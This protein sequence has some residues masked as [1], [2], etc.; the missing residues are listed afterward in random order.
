M[1]TP[2]MDKVQAFGKYAL[3]EKLGEG[4]LGPVYRG[5]DQDLGQAVVIRILCDGIKWDPAIEQLYNTHCKAIADL[6]HRNIVAIHDFG[7]EGQ[8][9]YIVME[10]LGSHSIKDIIVQK[11]A[12][13]VETKLSMMIQVAEGM[14]YAHK[15]G[16]LHYD[17]GPSKIHLTS[18]GCIKIRDFGIASVLKNRLPHPAVRFGV[19]IYLSPEQVQ[20]KNGDV[21]SDI[22][23][24]GTIFYELITY[25]HPFHDPN[26]NIALD[27]ILSDKPIPTFERFPEAPP[28]IWTILKTCL[29]KDPRDRYPNMDELV[30][31]C[32]DLQQS[33]AE[34]TRLM[35]AELYASMN[36]L[37][38][39]AAQPGASKETQNL[40]QEI[41]NLSHGDKEAD[42]TSLDR[43]VTVL[44][45]QYP[46]IQAAANLPDPISP[47]LFPEEKE[48]VMPAEPEA[49]SSENPDER[50]DGPPQEQPVAAAVVPDT[51]EPVAESDEIPQMAFDEAPVE[52]ETIEGLQ[53]EFAKSDDFQD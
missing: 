12:I 36:S 25:L 16:I 40:L 43:L 24:A 2:P 17:L 15:K 52:E 4:Y 11:S 44:T 1:G 49:I 29:A 21:R 20:K 6:Q 48:A 42:Y 51:P 10:S 28:G 34:D 35:I 41:Q 23:A 7:K 3:I 33:L 37:K 8:D 45:D 47:Q 22:F 32:R 31:A 46:A 13:T 39:A 26:S 38:K 19:P 30:N 14:S 27:N 50:I 18:D 5:F 53:K 9:T